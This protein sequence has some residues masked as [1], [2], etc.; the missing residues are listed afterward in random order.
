M[1]M[2]IYPFTEEYVALTKYLPKLTQCM[3]IPIVSV[4]SDY[5]DKDI[6]VFDGGKLTDCSIR[7]NNK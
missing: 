4:G 5:I 7:D 2:L 3:E 1:K 6:Y